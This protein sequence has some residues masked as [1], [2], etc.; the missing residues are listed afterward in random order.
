VEGKLNL[1]NYP[2]LPRCIFHQYFIFKKGHVISSHSIASHALRYYTP[3]HRTLSQYGIHN[4]VST[5]PSSSSINH[6]SRSLITLHHLSQTHTHFF[7]L[8]LSIF[9]FTVFKLGISLIIFNVV[10]YGY[11]FIYAIFFFFFL[12]SPP[13]YSFCW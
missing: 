4:A 3:L 7:P 1:P 2:R 10:V 6:F 8:F 13:L 12:F 11:L 9:S 5:F